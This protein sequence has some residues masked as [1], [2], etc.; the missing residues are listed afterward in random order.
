MSKTKNKPHY[1]QETPTL[2]SPLSP[3]T[4]IYQDED[5]V[6]YLAEAMPVDYSSTYNSYNYNS[7][8]Q[9]PS[10][11]TSPSHSIPS[12]RNL[13]HHQS[14]YPY[15]NNMISEPVKDLKLCL[16]GENKDTFVFVPGLLSYDTIE[17]PLPGGKSWTI[18]D[19]WSDVKE[20]I[21]DPLIVSPNPFGSVHDRAVQIYYQ[22]KGG[23]VDYGLQHSHNFCHKQLGATYEGLMP[24]WSPD[25]PVVLIGKGY[26]ATTA[27]HL[28]HLLSTNFFGQ[29]T[30]GTMI[31]G[32]IC[33]SAPH[34]GSTLPY[35]LGL[36]PGSKCHVNTISILQ[37]FLSIIHL[38]CYFTFL[39]RIF[40]FQLNEQWGLSSKSKGG[41]QS[42]WNAITARSRFSY[43]GDNFLLDWSVEGARQRY[44]G[45]EKD[46][47]HLDDHCV[48]IN[49]V[50]TGHSWR[51]KVTG[52]FWPRLTWKNLQTSIISTLLGQYKFTP[53]EEQQVLRTQSST[54]WQND[55]TLPIYSQC[56]PPHQKVLMNISLD[57]QLYDPL[58]HEIQPGIWY[59]VYVEDLSKTI[60]FDDVP[61]LFTQGL[62][63][64]SII[65][66]IGQFSSNYNDTFENYYVLGIETLE[67]ITIIIKN[68]IEKRQSDKAGSEWTQ[69]I[70][71][72]E[73]INSPSKLLWW[74]NRFQKMQE[75]SG[76]NNKEKGDGTSSTTTSFAT[77]PFMPGP[78]F[79]RDKRKMTVEDYSATIM[80]GNAGG[81]ISSSI[82]SKPNGKQKNQNNSQQENIKSNNVN[83]NTTGR[84]Q[85]IQVYQ[86]G[87]SNDITTTDVDAQFINPI[88]FLNTM[89]QKLKTTAPPEYSFSHDSVTG[90]F[91]CQVHFCGQ[92]Y[93]N[94]IAKPKKQTAKEEVACIAMRDL[95]IRM[96]DITNQIR[97]EL[98]RAQISSQK[99]L[100]P[101]SKLWYDKQ[102]QQAANN[103]QKKRPCVLL[104]E[105]CQMHKLGHPVYDIR[106]DG[107]GNYLFNC[108]INDRTFTPEVAFWQKNDAK[109][110]VSTIAFNVLFKE[111]FPTYGNVMA[112]YPPND[113]VYIANNM[114]LVPANYVFTNNGNN[115]QNHA[116][117]P[118]NS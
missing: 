54:F 113:G 29:H 92:T 86:N 74:M 112:M 13:H 18:A 50:T 49:Y 114:S 116:L 65:K 59:N 62:S 16:D 11:P 104:L 58:K 46:K 94:Q 15:N 67:K 5:E 96:P 106:D 110:H 76:S 111:I 22:I 109:D 39:Q 61:F 32:I 38:I 27:L 100:E 48:Y 93:Q 103:R 3:N 36:V 72:M 60:L 23:Q 83:I 25:N 12:S 117:I 79:V 64:L 107:R 26:G 57:D 52:H 17:L 33:L 4:N 101:K 63:D 89:H 31:K 95:S 91:Y 44:A 41:E 77:A 24:D 73:L 87:D 53:E 82:I 115:G 108:T 35:Y 43:F 7:Q 8:L 118:R 30:S 97:A 99:K 66:K 45:D 19:N 85:Q 102:Q 51:S 20:M 9:P 71:T 78:M 84:N 90:Q 37:F 21:D 40:D 10:S 34:R 6:P 14:F 56:P 28:Q 98:I 80:N 1:Q 47:H 88:S 105:F 70:E 69:K 2:S 81:I 75:N 42:L 68:K 55:G